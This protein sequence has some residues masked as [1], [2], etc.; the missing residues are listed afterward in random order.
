MQKIILTQENDN[1][2]IEIITIKN[3]KVVSRLKDWAVIDYKENYLAANLL[4]NLFTNIGEMI[5]DNSLSWGGDNN[6]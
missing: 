6:D 2:E 1:L 5:G 4:D 3:H